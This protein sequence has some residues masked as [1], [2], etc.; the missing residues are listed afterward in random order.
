MVLN[1]RGVFQDGL[2]LIVG[3]FVVAIGILVVYAVSDLMNTAFQ[4]DNNLPADTKDH[5]NSFNTDFPS[6]FDWVFM[7]VFIGLII[8]GILL[9]YVVPSNPLIFVIMILFTIIVGGLG[10][11]ISNAWDESTDEGLLQNSA[12]NF[13]MMDFVLNNFLTVMIIVFVL[14]TIVF[15]AKPEGGFN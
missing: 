14:M 2:L 9:A 5:F 6:I 7:T 8:G 4:G 10:G 1:K 13:P 11:Y 12:S 15:Y 3:F